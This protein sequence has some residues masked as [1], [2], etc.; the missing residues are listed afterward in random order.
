[1]HYYRER[2]REACLK[3]RRKD[4]YDKVPIIQFQ[5]FPN[6]INRK[7]HYH[8]EAEDLETLSKKQMEEILGISMS[9]RPRR[10]LLRR[11]LWKQ[12]DG[13]T[14][15]LEDWWK[16]DYIIAGFMLIMTCS[17]G[18]FI[19]YA[20]LSDRL[21]KVPQ[22]LLMT[23]DRNMDAL[24]FADE[25]LRNSRN[26]CLEYLISRHFWE[27]YYYQ[28]LPAKFKEDYNFN[29][30]LIHRKPSYISSLRTTLRD[31][32]EIALV[33]VVKGSYNLKYL[34]DRLKDDDEIISIV[35]D[36]K[37]GWK[38]LRRYASQR[39]QNEPRFSTMITE[40]QAEVDKAEALDRAKRGK[41]QR[42]KEQERLLQDSTAISAVSSQ[43]WRM[44]SGQPGL[45]FAA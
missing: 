28:Y 18:P 4:Y 43:L 9:K 45:Y 17:H 42:D 33:A 20:W 38:Y 24:Q 12:Y 13:F 10:K 39:L 29:L 35:A 3:L 37:D 5:G 19:H 31:N 32:K 2:L 34:S 22:L 11:M 16:D 14:D 1:M 23:D 36:Q 6:E 44:I 26:L 30:E 27:D 41:W 8:R 25:S 7:I 15:E 40:G 21:K